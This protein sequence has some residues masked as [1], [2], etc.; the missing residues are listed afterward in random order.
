MED[1]LFD[2]EMFQSPVFQRPFQYLLRLDTGRQLQDV[3]AHQVEGTEKD[4][5]KVL[6]R[7]VYSLLECFF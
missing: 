5:L 4:C 7:Y 1:Q 3:N 6:L 2:L